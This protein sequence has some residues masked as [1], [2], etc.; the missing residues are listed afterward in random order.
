[1][2]IPSKDLKS[3]LLSAPLGMF[4]EKVNTGEKIDLVSFGSISDR[5]FTKKGLLTAELGTLIRELQTSYSWI[6]RN[7]DDFRVVLKRKLKN[8]LDPVSLDNF[9]YHKAIVLQSFIFTGRRDVISENDHREIWSSGE[10]N[11]TIRSYDA[12]LDTCINFDSDLFDQKK[13][14]TDD[15][16]VKQKRSE[17]YIPSKSIEELTYEN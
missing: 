8:A 2:L 12:I 5:L 17:G 6:N 4:F 9:F 7:N 1:M 16:Y 15:L 3:Q 13:E 11:L 10:L 14:I